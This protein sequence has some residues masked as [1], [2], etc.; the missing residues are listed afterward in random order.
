[1]PMKGNAEKGL[2]VLILPG[3][4]TA[5]PAAVNRV[6][7]GS[8]PTPAAIIKGTRSKCVILNIVC[9]TRDEGSNPHWA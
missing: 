2:A 8:S 7:V 9:K 1:M 5:E 3:S 6:V 4:S